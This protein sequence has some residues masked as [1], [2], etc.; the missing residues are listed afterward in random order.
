MR[1][2][3]HNLQILRLSLLEGKVLKI[4]LTFVITIKFDT[5]KAIMTLHGTCHETHCDIYINI[6]EVKQCEI[7]RRG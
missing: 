5:T 7:V 4:F 2:L 6:C 1:Y 3:L